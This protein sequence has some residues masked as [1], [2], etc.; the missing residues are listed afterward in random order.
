MMTYI[1]RPQYHLGNLDHF[2]CLISEARPLP[3]WIHLNKRSKKFDK[4][5]A[6]PLHMD[7]SIILARLCQCAPH[8]M[9]ASL[10]QSESTTQMTYRL[11]E[12]FLHRVPI[13]YNGLP[14]PPLKIAPSNGRSGPHLIHGSLGPHKCISQQ[15]LDQFSHFCRAHNHDRLTDRQTDHIIVHL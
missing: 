6:S 12:P 14:L 10:G 4:K 11:I 3:H 13:L 8:L 2:I 7:G 9:H 5:A 15:H 1:N